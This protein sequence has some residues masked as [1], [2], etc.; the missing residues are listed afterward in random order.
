M[1]DGPTTHSNLM[2]MMMISQ[3]LSKGIN[4]TFYAPFFFLKYPRA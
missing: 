1:L 4:I 3:V 2:M